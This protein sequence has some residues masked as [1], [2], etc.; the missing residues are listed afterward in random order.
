MQEFGRRM[1]GELLISCCLYPTVIL[2][3]YFPSVPVSKLPELVYET[4]KDLTKLGLKSTIVGHV[5][6]GKPPSLLNA[7]FPL[8]RILQVTSMH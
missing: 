8:I 5:G 4:K 6:D 1:S 7:R 3:L 2:I